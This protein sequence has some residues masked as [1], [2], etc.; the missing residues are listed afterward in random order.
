MR[1]VARRVVVWKGVRL[2]PGVEEEAEL[3]GCG[4]VS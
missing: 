1:V 3:A 2:G 4:V